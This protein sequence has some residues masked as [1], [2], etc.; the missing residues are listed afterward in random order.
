MKEKYSQKRYPSTYEIEQ[1]LL[2]CRRGFNDEFAQS[3]GIFV[4][5]ATKEQM[6]RR[7]SHFFYDN[8]DLE[9]IR[10][11]AYQ[12]VSSRTLS[13]FVISSNDQD[14]D[15]IHVLEHV[16][17]TI[18]PKKGISLSAIKESN[19]GDSAKHL[20]EMDYTYTKPGRIQ[21]LQDEPRNIE[22]TVAR[23]DDNSYQIFVQ[24]DSSAD[25]KKFEGFIKASMANEV[26]LETL[27]FERLN[28]QQT[29]AFFD[30][31]AESGMDSE[32]RR[33][34]VNRLVFRKGAVEETEVEED[35]LTGINRAILEGRDLRDNAFVKQSEKD[36]Y[37]FSAMT[38]EYE[39]INHPYLIEVKAEFKLRPEVF[40][41]GIDG[42][43]RRELNEQNEPIVVDA[44]LSSEDEVKITTF[45]WH[46]AK[47][48]YSNLVSA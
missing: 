41:V 44:D 37:R 25:A 21:F 27:E 36:G 30:D 26:L 32:W 4:N 29:V 35:I 16:R 46:R 45:M 33:T 8:S 20:G 22:Y 39:N 7:L 18:D 1:A 6:A 12:A 42:Y 2:M 48:V 19:E 3:R 34:Q 15:P 40:E 17:E 23:I 5:R 11:R 10:R 38:I 31:L 13:G 28:S 24:A 9:A 47:A 14:F 43:K